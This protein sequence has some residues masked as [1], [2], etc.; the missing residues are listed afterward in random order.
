MKENSRGQ[1]VL[2]AFSMTSTEFVGISCVCI[3]N[4]KKR[5]AAHQHVDQ[6]DKQN[7]VTHIL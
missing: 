4:S 1:I 3:N 5:K 6:G 2:N 7:K